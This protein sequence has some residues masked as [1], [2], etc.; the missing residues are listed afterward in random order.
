MEALVS[1]DMGSFSQVPPGVQTAA[2]KRKEQLEALR[3]RDE[4][5]LKPVQL[6][7]AAE[8]SD[9]MK[10]EDEKA[11]KIKVWGKCQAYLK[12]FPQRLAMI[13]AP[14]EPMKKSL[15]ELQFMLSE[16]HA[17]L[18]KTGA[19][20]LMT[21]LYGEAMVGIENYH[22]QW[23]PFKL[24]LNGLGKVTEQNLEKLIH[25]LMEELV[26]EYDWFFSMGIIPRILQATAGLMLTTHRM[27]A[28]GIKRYM[29]AAVNTP[30]SENLRAQAEKLKQKRA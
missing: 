7:Q 15:E 18:G 29:Q 22:H 11:E 9:Q 2:D 17:Q 28:E 26:I 21:A 27:N 8:F 16:I 4:K 19:A 6:K 20:D 5:M 14:K 12:S 13:K 10:H 25:P 3:A 30:V 23:N 24:N 1:D